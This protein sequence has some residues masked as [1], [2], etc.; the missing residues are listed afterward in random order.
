MGRR[1]GCD[2]ARFSQPWST[3]SVTAM[4]MDEFFNHRRFVHRLRQKEPPQRNALPDWL[5][6]LS[7]FENASPKPRETPEWFAPLTEAQV[8]EI[9]ANI[10]RFIAR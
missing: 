5:P 4:K 3:Y 7:P 1:P 6:W 2:I 9:E 8:A 10:S